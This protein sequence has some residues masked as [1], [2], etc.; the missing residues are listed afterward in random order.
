MADAQEVFEL[1]GFLGDA[2]RKDVRGAPGRSDLDRA[3]VAPVP[4]GRRRRRPAAG[5]PRRRGAAPPPAA[6]GRAP[7]PTP[8]RR[9]LSP[10]QVQKMAL[11]IVAGLT[12]S[13]DGINRLKPAGD[14]LIGR[15]FRLVP[16]RELSGQVGLGVAVVA[17]VR[18]G[19]HQ[20]AW[21]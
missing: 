11:D 1:I 2:S 19:Q 21:E 5:A 14:G 16:D 9:A 13:Q 18:A 12:A 7:P 8:P 17:G 10:T 15:L 3:A 4:R 6:A 20:C